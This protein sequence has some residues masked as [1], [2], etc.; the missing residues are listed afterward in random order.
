MSVEGIGTKI[1]YYTAM[2]RLKTLRICYVEHA[3]DEI[4]LQEMLK[5][6]PFYWTP[7]RVYRAQIFN[8]AGLAAEYEMKTAKQGWEWRSMPKS[9]GLGLWNRALWK[10]GSPSMLDAVIIRTDQNEWR[11]YKVK[12]EEKTGRETEEDRQTNLNNA[13][14]IREAMRWSYEKHHELA[15]KSG[16]SPVGSE[17]QQF[18]LYGALSTRFQASGVPINTITERLI[19][20]DLLPFLYL[21]QDI[22][23]EAVAEYVVYKEMPKDARISWLT[24]IVQQGCQIGKDKNQDEYSELM[25]TAEANG[26]VWLLLLEARGTDYFW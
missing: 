6:E 11:V 1:F 24:T 5:A 10:Q 4:H 7:G 25:E 14:G 20:A 21:E 16:L 13:E 17:Q 15:V 8:D 23:R 12:A 9:L 3:T 26:A 22:A 18:A 2:G 19:W